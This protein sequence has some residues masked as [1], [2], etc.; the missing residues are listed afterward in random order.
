V[1][2]G[3]DRKITLALQACVERLIA[4]L[5]G[6]VHNGARIAIGFALLA[7]GVIVLVARSSTPPPI[8]ASARFE[9]FTNGGRT[10]LLRLTNQSSR[11]LF[12]GPRCIES[13]TA[14]GWV[15]FEESI[16]TMVRTK[17][18][19]ILNTNESCVFTR[20]VPQTHSAW[21]VVLVCQLEP[22]DPPSFLRRLFQALFSRVGWTLSD[23][24]SEFMIRTDEIPR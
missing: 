10:A 21:R 2:E 18:P 15:R 11:Y 7:I 24:R 3:G 13:K 16:E 19:P 12:C 8:Q 23:G 17:L 9:G 5:G 20:A 6:G 14:K 4:R 22:P 1:I